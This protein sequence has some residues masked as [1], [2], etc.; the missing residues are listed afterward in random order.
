MPLITSRPVQLP[1]G[2]GMYIDALR[3]QYSAIGDVWLLEP[4][5]G[6]TE[7]RACWDLLVFADGGVLDAVRADS[8]SH[9]GD[10]TLL[11]VVDGDRF[12]TAWGKSVSGR[13]SDMGWRV[14]DLHNASFAKRGAANSEERASA[15]RV[16]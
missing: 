16:R 14:E 1:E 15:S 6:G 12:E 4:E 10:V 7:T 13:L 3:K 11:V 2:I 8:A 9:R 5:Q